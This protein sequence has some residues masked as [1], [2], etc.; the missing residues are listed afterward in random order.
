[1]PVENSTTVQTDPDARLHHRHQ[2]FKNGKTISLST[3]IRFGTWTISPL[4]EGKKLNQLFYLYKS[5]YLYMH[6][7][8]H[9]SAECEDQNVAQEGGSEGAD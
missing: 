3:N 2:R 5:I 6:H 9:P 7:Y 8:F 1:M 4:L